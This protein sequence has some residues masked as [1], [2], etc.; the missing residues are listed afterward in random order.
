LT[1]NVVI[2]TLFLIKIYF[3]AERPGPYLAAV[4]FCIC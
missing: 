4:V 1:T 3:V 2:K